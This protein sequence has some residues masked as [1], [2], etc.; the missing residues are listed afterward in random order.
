MLLFQFLYVSGILYVYICICAHIC[1]CKIYIFLRYLYMVIINCF[2]IEIALY[3]RLL[4]CE[5]VFYLCIDIFIMISLYIELFC[6]YIFKGTSKIMFSN[7]KIRVQRHIL[8]VRHHNILSS[9]RLY[10]IY[11]C[12]GSHLRY[13]ALRQRRGPRSFVC[14]HVFGPPP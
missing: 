10:W 9:I 13:L 14:E 12:A 1:V 7:V 11:I 6:D 8:C 2:S 4:A 5:N 3:S